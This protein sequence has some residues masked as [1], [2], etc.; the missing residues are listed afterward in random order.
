MREN[1]SDSK[2]H[3]ECMYFEFLSSMSTLVILLSFVEHVEFLSSMSTLV[4]DSVFG[5]KV[6]FV[7]VLSF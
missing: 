5:D 1:L 6:P 4:L 7:C 3:A 2:I